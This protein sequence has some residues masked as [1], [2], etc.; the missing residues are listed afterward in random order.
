MLE[1]WA[2]G[3]DGGLTLAH[4][5]GFETAGDELRLKRCDAAK[6]SMAKDFLDQEL[7]PYAELAS[8]C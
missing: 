2:A 8:S 3:V 1:L 5:V 6:L 7:A 4:C